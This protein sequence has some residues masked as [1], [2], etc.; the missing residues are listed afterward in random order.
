MRTEY[1]SA[2]PMQQYSEHPSEETLER[3][4]LHQM[5]ED[6]LEGVETHIMACHNCVTRLEELEIDIAAT[7][8]ALADLHRQAVAKNYAA[9]LARR[10]KQSR[11]FGFGWLNAKSLSFAGAAAALALTLTIAPRYSTVEKDIS[12]FRGAETNTI[13]ANRTV[14]LHLNAR[15]LP[16]HSVSV[17]VVNSEGEEIWNSPSKVA[18]Q[19]VNAKLPPIETKGNYFLRIYSA[20]NNEN[21]GELLREFSFNVQ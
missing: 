17:E 2:D 13:P 1:L 5:K 18:G 21:R 20:N 7:K 3:F 14:L 6:E 12:A 10:E 9:E 15:D 19:T 11:R 16:Q 8:M 4:L